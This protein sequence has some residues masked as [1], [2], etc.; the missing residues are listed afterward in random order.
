MAYQSCAASLAANIA[1]DCENPIVGGYTGRGVI[2][3]WSLAPVLTKSATNPRIVSAIGLEEGQHVIAVDNVWADA[4]S[5]SNTASNGDSGRVQFTKNFA[6]RVPK[7]GAQAAKEIIEPL[8]KLPL[9]FLSILEKTDKTGDGSFE[10]VG[11]QSGMK[12]NADGI[13]RTESENGGD[14]TI[15]ASCV[16][17]Y[18]EAVL[19]DTDYATSLELFEALLAKAY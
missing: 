6:F 17:N 3:P 18:A 2:I 14:W 7:R 4:F 1:A 5:G 19:F 13:A 11:L 10:I 8:A 12:V 15:A 9:G 16:E